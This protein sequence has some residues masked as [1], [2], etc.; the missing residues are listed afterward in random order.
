MADLETPTANTPS[1]PAESA[2]ARPAQGVPLLRPR[3]YDVADSAA[4]FD[5]DECHVVSPRSKALTTTGEG[6]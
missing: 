2:P 4:V 1:A 6:G 5:F 3:H